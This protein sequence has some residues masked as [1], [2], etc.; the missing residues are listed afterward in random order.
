MIGLIRLELTSD[1]G[2]TCLNRNIQRTLDNEQTKGEWARESLQGGALVWCPTG[3]TG[4]TA[5]RTNQRRQSW[6]NPQEPQLRQLVQGLGPSLPWVMG[7]RRYRTKSAS[8]AAATRCLVCKQRRGQN[9]M[10]CLT[11]YARRY[12][13]KKKGG[14][15]L[16]PLLTFAL[17]QAETFEMKGFIINV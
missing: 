8:A 3:L 2:S 11:N 1:L 6:K 10:S 13:G 12:P 15:G 17:V 14:A 7:R 16:V 4:S 9:K 5:V